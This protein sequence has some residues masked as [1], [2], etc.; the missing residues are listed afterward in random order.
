MELNAEQKEALNLMLEGKNVF[1]TGEAG[2]GKSTVLREF[3]RLQGE[4]T[5]FLAPTGIAAVQLGGT[6]LHSFFLFPPGLLTPDSLEELSGKKRLTLIRSV[7]TL[8]IDEISMVRSDLFQAIDLRLRSV[9]LGK[10]RLK[11][12]GG[13][14]II[15][16]GDFFQLPPVL[17]TFTEEA[18]LQRE[19]G[20]G[21]A[22]QI[23]LWD[24]A[25]FHCLSLKHPHRQGKDPVFIQTLNAIRHGNLLEPAIPL[26]GELLSPLDTLNRLCLAPPP[27]NAPPPI[28]LCTTNREAIAFNAAMKERLETPPVLF[29]AQ[30]VGRFREAD[31]PTEALL[32]L[33]A[34]ARVMLLC[35]KHL[36][37]GEMEYVNGDLGTILDIQTGEDTPCIQVKL[38]KGPTVQVGLFQ[39]TTYE[40]VLEREGQRKF[41]R[42][43]PVGYFVQIPLKLAYAITIHKAQGLTLEQVE[44]HLGN[45]C[46]AH[47]QLYTALSRCTTLQGLHLDR[48]I[49]KDDLILDSDVV[50]FYEQLETTPAPRENVTLSIPPEHEAAMRAFLAQLMA[51]PPTTAPAPPQQ[52]PRETP[53]ETPRETPQQTPRETPREAEAADL[54]KAETIRKH[55]SLD[56]LVSLYLKHQRGETIFSE[57]DA[58]ILLPLAQKYLAKGFLLRQDFLLLQKHIHKYHRFLRLSSRRRR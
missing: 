45:G 41:L 8:V 50:H 19:L 35:N 15:L 2:T 10:D 5:V 6:T 53:K 16:C 51:H 11:P 24:E 42:Q 49:R 7:R 17:K 23:P 47:G 12:F 34:G 1:L 36:P 27:D 39:W 56:L 29:T 9:A 37:N 54:P 40:Y 55:P 18:Y 46:F 21:Y 26:Q 58:S 38:D 57:A 48:P 32:E 20:G 14:Q 25:G 22:F 4:K 33:K 43:R 31:F 28:R 52:T 44:L 30:V 3:Q 13:K